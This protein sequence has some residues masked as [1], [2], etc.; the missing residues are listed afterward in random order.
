MRSLEFI[1]KY[2][3]ETGTDIS[4]ISEKTGIPLN[5]LTQ[6]LNGQRKMPADEFVEI[7]LA[8]QANPLDFAEADMEEPSDKN[9]FK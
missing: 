6:S 3:E 2:L 7:C 1:N 9:T 5:L 4:S 8:I